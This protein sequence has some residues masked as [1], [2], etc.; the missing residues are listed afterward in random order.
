MSNMRHFSALMLLQRTVHNLRAWIVLLVLVVFKNISNPKLLVLG[1]LIF[2]LLAVAQAYYH[3]L[4]YRFVLNEK[5]LLMHYG[6]IFKHQIDIP[7]ERIQ[8]VHREVWFL[9]KPFKVAKLTIETAGSRSGKDDVV[10]EAVPEFIYRE[11]E[12]KRNHGAELPAAKASVQT[13]LYQVSVNDLFVFTFT[14]L[15]LVS[16][17]LAM[18]GIYSEAGSLAFQKWVETRLNEIVAG[19]ILMIALLI[20]LILFIL[21]IVVLTRNFLRYFRFFVWRTDDHLIIERGLFT[22]R[23]V[24]IPIQRIQALQLRQSLLRR[25]LGLQ[26]VEVILA[27]GQG[28]NKKEDVNDNTFYLLPIIR[29]KEVWQMLQKLLPEWQPTALVPNSKKS[30]WFLFARFRLLA[31]LILGAAAIYFFNL[32][33]GII[34]IGLLALFVAISFWTADIQTAALDKNS[35]HTVTVAGISRIE[36][37]CPF[38][39]IQSVK[40]KTTYYLERYQWG[41]FEHFVKAGRIRRR[42]K[43]RYLDLAECTRLKQRVL[44]GR[45]TLKND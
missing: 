25:L 33:W 16:V 3:W 37:L 44:A 13:T 15:N 17:L 20:L 8:A 6:F 12:K 32:V 27:A 42:I 41:H 2:L 24:S 18:L 10:L 1:L 9:F 19:G 43:L 35:L 21:F 22:R 23:R 7:Y 38:N 5:H 34:V 36:T 28:D 45:T 4:S 39:K 40:L 31:L 11:L 26:T 30:H 14:D 29:D